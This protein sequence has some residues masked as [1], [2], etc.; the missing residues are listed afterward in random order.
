MKPG[1]IIQR[2]ATDTEMWE[3]CTITKQGHKY[4]WAVVS[5]NLFSETCLLM[6]DKLRK[7]FPD[8]DEIQALY[9]DLSVNGF[10]KTRK[11]DE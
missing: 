9:V 5:E 11:D 8:L 3:I 2:N 7:G 4:V 10:T 6:D 1:L